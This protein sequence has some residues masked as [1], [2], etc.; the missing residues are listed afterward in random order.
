MH[1]KSWFNLFFL[2]EFVKKGQRYEEDESSTLC[3]R[4]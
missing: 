2:D 1:F 3:V 4:S